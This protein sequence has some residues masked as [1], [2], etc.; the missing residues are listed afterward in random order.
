MKDNT[1]FF[2]NLKLRVGYGTRVKQQISTTT[3]ILLPTVSGHYAINWCRLHHLFRLWHARQQGPE[4]GR[5]PAPPTNVGL[6]VSIFNSHFNLSVNWY[7]NVSSSLLIKQDSNLYGLQRPVPEYRFHPQS[8][9]G[10][11]AEL[12]QYPHEG[13]R[14]DDGLQHRFNRSRCS[15][16]TAIIAETNNFIQTYESRMASR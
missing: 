3:C 8:G 15:T 2:Q 5:K 9:R 13:F 10:S 7:N 11:G 14:L 1:D 4:V 12:Y 6:D 16:S